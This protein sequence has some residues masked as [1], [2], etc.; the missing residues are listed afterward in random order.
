MFA[1]VQI[2]ASGEM[3]VEAVDSSYAA[4]EN[5]VQ[6]SFWA[7]P[8]SVFI[9]PVEDLREDLQQQAEAMIAERA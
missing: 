8:E 1:V 2:L 9:T 3:R 6:S 5:T 4:C 7:D